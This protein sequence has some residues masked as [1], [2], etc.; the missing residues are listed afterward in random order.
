[1]YLMYISWQVPILNAKCEEI[2][3]RGFCG[4]VNSFA[5]GNLIKKKYIQADRV[6]MASF[7]KLNSVKNSVLTSNME[8]NM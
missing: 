1:M 4:V 2:I 3:K 5:G 8:I 6:I 7:L